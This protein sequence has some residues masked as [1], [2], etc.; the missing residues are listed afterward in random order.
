MRIMIV[1]DEQRARRG[2]HNLIISLS[3]EYEVVSIVAN[4]VKALEIIPTIKPDVVFTDLKM[5]YMSGLELINA[6]KELD[7]DTKFVIISA[8]EQF[9]VARKAISLNVVDYL[10]K[11]ITL[12]ELESVLK[13]LE[14]KSMNTPSLSK[15]DIYIEYPEASQYTV[16]VISI[17]Q[18]CYKSK[19]N[20]EMIAEN[21]GITKEYLSYLFHKE[22]GQTFSK[23]LKKYRIQMAKCLI[24]NEGLPKEDIPY[25]VGFSDPKYFN[26]VFK[27]IEGISIGRFLQ[28]NLKKRE[29]S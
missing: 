1:E 18:E 12:D 3:D 22:T 13:R 11:P 7:I 8:Y 17:I 9:E 25:S 21:L 27:E 28:K 16:K 29:L 24:I 20:Q 6:I 14:N 10:V 15:E 26:K 19:I 4:G 23:Y 2:L 5:P